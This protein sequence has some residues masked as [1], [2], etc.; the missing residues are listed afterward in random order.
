MTHTTEI[1][2]IKEIEE[3]YPDEWVLLENPEV[4]EDLNVLGGTLLHHTKDRIELD[5]RALELRPRH[6]AFLY[7][8]TPD[9]DQAFLL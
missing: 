7:T 9:R 4:D 2:T 1:L 3:R 8:G 5:Q 6:S